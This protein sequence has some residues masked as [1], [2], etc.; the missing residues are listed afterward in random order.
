MTG[1]QQHHILDQN[2]QK[3]QILP[4]HNGILLLP[5]IYPINSNGKIPQMV[6][7]MRLKEHISS[8]YTTSHA[9]S[10]AEALLHSC[11]ERQQRK[12]SSPAHQVKNEELPTNSK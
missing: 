9:G 11:H 4:S 10:G 5:R 3:V 8:S 7:R 1:H 2:I 12:K 6:L